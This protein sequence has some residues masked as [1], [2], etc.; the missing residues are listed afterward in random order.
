MPSSGTW[1]CWPTTPGSLARERRAPR[2]TP[3]EVARGT[4]ETNVF[5]AI[6]V[7]NAMTGLLRRASCHLTSAADWPLNAASPLPT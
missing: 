4:Y 1:T 7:T 5:G 2:Q 6:E 3:L